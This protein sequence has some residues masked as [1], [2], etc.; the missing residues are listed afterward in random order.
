[1]DTMFPFQIIIDPSISF[2]AVCSVDLF[3][4]FCDLFIRLLSL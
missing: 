4:D 1:M 2:A 3:Y